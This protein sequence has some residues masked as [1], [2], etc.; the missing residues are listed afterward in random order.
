M[1]NQFSRTALL[2]GQEGLSKLQS[3]KVYIFGLGGVGSYTAEAL[4]RAGIGFFKLVDFDEICLT[5]INRQLHALHSTIG[6]AKVEV[7]KQRILDINPN[8]KIETF[9][10]FYQEE[11]AEV[12]FAEKP[13]YVVDA[14]DTVKSKVSLA[15]ECHRRGIPLIS[16]MGAGNRLDALSF[17]VADI[18]K[19]SGCPLAKAVRKLLK[20]EGITQGFKVVFSP[21]P[22]LKPLEQETSCE[23]N[24]IC[25]SG[26]AH[27]SLKRQ[28]PGSISYVPS[29]AGLLMA[30]EVVKDIIKKNFNR[31]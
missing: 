4:A 14:I 29:M 31:D 11:G 13:D 6:K 28:I 18:S 24:C 3:S 20:R 5:N 9:Q 27:C 7:M 17:R 22:T 26:D 12:F 23:S 21:E 30:G 25:P 10:F 16:C 2:I 8:A 1:Q 15:K 19:T